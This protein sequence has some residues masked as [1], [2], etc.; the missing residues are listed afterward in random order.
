MY[1]KSE[2][3]SKK[4]WHLNNIS[5]DREVGLANMEP[6]TTRKQMCLKQVYLNDVTMMLWTFWG[7]TRATPESHPPRQYIDKRK[8][9]T[10]RATLRHEKLPLTYDLCSLSATVLTD[11]FPHASHPLEV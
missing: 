5:A 6:L 2:V 11:V 3:G 10:T 9:S 4:N 8:Y 1:G 7:D